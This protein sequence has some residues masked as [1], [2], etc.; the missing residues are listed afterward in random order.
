MAVMVLAKSSTDCNDWDEVPCP[1]DVAFPFCCTESDG[2]N[3]GA[4]ECE[5]FGYGAIAYVVDCAHGCAF[6]FCKYEVEH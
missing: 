6:G 5:G 3:T 4:V 2:S 1:S